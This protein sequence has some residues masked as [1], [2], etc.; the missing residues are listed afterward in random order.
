ML[1]HAQGQ[2]DHDLDRGHAQ[3]EET[4]ITDQEV[5]QTVEAEVVVETG[6]VA[7]VGHL[8]GHDPGQGQ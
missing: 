6:V 2:E 4:N 1:G 5:D 7:G 3:E 8:Q